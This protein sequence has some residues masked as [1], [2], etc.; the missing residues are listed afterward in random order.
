VVDYRQA[1]KLS[2]QS[3]SVM[4][5]LGMALSELDQLDEAKQLLVRVRRK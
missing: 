3:S 1:Q 4:I 5:K 2:P